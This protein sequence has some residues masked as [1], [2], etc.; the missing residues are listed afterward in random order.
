MILHLVTFRFTDDVTESDVAAL[1]EALT[2]MATRVDSLRSYVAGA[3]L[4]IRP[5][6]DYAVAAIVDDA[7]GLEAYLDHPEHTGVYE[8]LLGRMVAERSAA[9]LPLAAGAL[10]KG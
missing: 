3:N 7:A 1:T 4:H 8:R 10:T 2:T 9:Q 6:A 5:G